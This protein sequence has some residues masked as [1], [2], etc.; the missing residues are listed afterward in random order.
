MKTTKGFAK[1]ID[2]IINKLNDLRDDIETAVG[3]YDDYEFEHDGLTS[4]QEERRDELQD[5]MDYIDNAINEL[6]DYSS[7]YL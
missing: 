6:S 1:R 7:D 5:E 4:A 3:E 2:A